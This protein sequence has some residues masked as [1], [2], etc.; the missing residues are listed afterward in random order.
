MIV[1]S[2]VIQFCLR[3]SI[4]ALDKAKAISDTNIYKY[5]SNFKLK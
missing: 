3:L 1:N 4:P 5:P 2:N